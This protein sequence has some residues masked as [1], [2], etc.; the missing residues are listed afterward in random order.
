[1]ARRR[2]GSPEASCRYLHYKLR[3]G[4]V[5]LL[6]LVHVELVSETET[7]TTIGLLDSGATT[8]FIPY[9]MADILGLIPEKP[10]SG[11]VVT[12]G[13]DAPFFPAKV[14]KLAI[15]IGGKILTEF[16]NIRVLVPAQ[17]ERD[18]PYVILGRDSVFKRFHITFKENV[19]KFILEH[20]KL[21]NKK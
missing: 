10:E 2:C 16:A 19:K 5:I 18:L 11:S 14:K 21:A 13:G 7:F 6:P 1:L 4:R 15:L 3:N 9:E 12:A 8:T 17:P 20:H